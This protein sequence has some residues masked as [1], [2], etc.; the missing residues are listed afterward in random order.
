MKTLDMI[1]W[2]M[3]RLPQLFLMSSRMCDLRPTVG[4]EICFRLTRVLKI[5]AGRPPR[6]PQFWPVLRLSTARRRGQ[7]SGGALAA[8]G[9]RQVFA[10]T[11]APGR[12]GRRGQ[13]PSPY[14]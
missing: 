8:G 6:S 1:S 4:R 14:K 3:K 13:L 5:Q 7:L 11:Q 10:R 2:D 9:S 12:Q